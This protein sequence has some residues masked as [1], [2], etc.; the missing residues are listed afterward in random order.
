MSKIHREEQERVERVI[1]ESVLCH[2]GMVDENGAPYVIPMSFGY[3]EGVIY[4]HS[5]HEGRCITILEKNPRVCIT[6][7]TSPVLL[8]QNEE[9]ACSYGMQASSVMC[10]GKVVFE[11]VYEQ[12]V[13]ALNV[14]M[15]H[16]TDRDF[17]Y[18][19]P[20]VNNVKIWKVVIEKASVR[21]FGMPSKN[22]LRFRSSRPL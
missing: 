21:E 15:R 9:V 8:W 10:H 7:C 1:T 19:E 20:A 4:L 3:E 18:S 17:S 16:Y 22:A 5:A 11:D 2:V 12:K 6:F 14:I 13:R